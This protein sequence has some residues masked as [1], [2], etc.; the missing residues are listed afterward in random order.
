MEHIGL[1]QMV[2]SRRTGSADK[3]GSLAVNKD[4]Y[5][6]SGNKWVRYDNNG[7]MI[8]GEDYR[9]GGWYYFNPTTGAM[10]KGMQYVPSN[11]GKWVY[12]DWTTGKMAHGEQYVN[13]DAQHTGWYLFD[14]YTGAMFHGDTY[15]RSNG[16]KWV[17]YDFTTGKMVKGLNRH[18][19]SWYYFD[20]TTGAMQK[21]RVWV[22]EWKSWHWFDPTT[23][24][25]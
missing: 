13:Y 22:P 2:G 8:K 4:V 18:D 21:G 1:E 23:G 12:Y 17:R 5:I 20:S 15:V 10:T 14:R 3:D 19:N 11:G 6:P 24:R 7:H 16:G 9:Y 25:G